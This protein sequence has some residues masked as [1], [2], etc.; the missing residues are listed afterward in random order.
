MK[1]REVC[2][3]QSDQPWYDLEL[4]SKGDDQEGWEQ[5]TLINTGYY[6]AHAGLD[7]C[8]FLLEQNRIKG[9]PLRP[10][11]LSYDCYNN[12][13]KITRQEWYHSAL[14]YPER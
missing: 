4:W 2:L 5:K 9:I 6:W 7:H 13:F 3:R 1:E 12:I 8:P 14:L 10:G 11:I